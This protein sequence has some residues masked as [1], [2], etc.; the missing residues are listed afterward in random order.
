MKRIKLSAMNFRKGICFF[1]T[2]NLLIMGFLMIFFANMLCSIAW[3]NNDYEKRKTEKGAFKLSNK[4][5]LEENQ[6]LLIVIFL[7]VFWIVF[8]IIV[9]CTYSS[10]RNLLI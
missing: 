7:N 2:V 10:I 3:Q 6:S 5:D 8:V 9:F 4:Y 1:V